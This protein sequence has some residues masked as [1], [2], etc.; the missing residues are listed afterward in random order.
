MD[1]VNE[2]VSQYMS[3]RSIILT[4]GRLLPALLLAAL[5]GACGAP[6]VGSS[7]PTTPAGQPTAV[8]QPTA[9]PTAVPQPTAIPLPTAIP[10]P[11][12]APAEAGVLPAPLYVRTDEFALVRLER[13]GKTIT[14]LSNESTPV[15]QFVVSPADGSVLYVTGDRASRKLVRVDAQ[16]GQRAELLVGNLNSPAW[17][18]D[19]SRYSVAWADGPEGAG[20]YTFDMSG[21]KPALV[22]A[23]KPRPKDG[24]QPGWG[25]APLAWSPDGQRLLLT[26]VPDYGPDLPGGDI[27]VVGYA[28]AG[29]DMQLT[30]LVRSGGDPH[31]C[32]EASWS[33]DSRQ[34]YCANYGA[35]GGKPALWRVDAATAQP[36]VLISSK[37]GE[38]VDVFNARQFGEQ[39]QAFVGRAKLGASS[40]IYRMQ[41]LSAA[42]GAAANLREEGYDTTAVLWSAWAPD[43][44]G[45]VLQAF[46]EGKLGNVLIWA[47]AAGG[48]PVDL[49]LHS[50]GVPAWGPAES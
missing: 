6:S 47:P 29:K 13:D 17:T 33:A 28:V 43:G 4:R 39:L 26:V 8:A 5:L 40:L 45:A 42:D 44:Q 23:D 10:Q 11:T 31:L 7:S 27:A 30:D 20:V 14:K 3:L 34:V 25:Y 12:A 1:Q 36:E 22:V 48:A 50:F 21:G 9:E 41:S 38:Q 32:L 18:P 15:D 46:E 35:S 16:G 49:K 19:G 24:S 37:D 2:G